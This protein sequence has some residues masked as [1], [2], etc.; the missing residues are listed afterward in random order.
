MER[1]PKICQLCGRDYTADPNGTANF[2]KHLARLTPCVQRTWEEMI[3]PTASDLPQNV[4]HPLRL[5]LPFLTGT[6][7]LRCFTKS[8][9]RNRWFVRT[10]D[11]TREVGIT[12]FTN[13]WLRLLSERFPQ[14]HPQFQGLDNWSMETGFLFL[15]NAPG[16]GWD[17]DFLVKS[18]D[19]QILNGVYHQVRDW[20]VPDPD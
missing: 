16:P 5:I 8:P 2:K 6:Q 3:T 10:A 7:T 11:G 19:G 12:A 20:L 9:N 13:M 1:P 14:D 18:D 4:K 15:G 17:P